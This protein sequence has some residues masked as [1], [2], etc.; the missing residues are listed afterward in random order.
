MKKGERSHTVLIKK[1]TKH[2]ELGDF[3]ASGANDG[4]AFTLIFF[5]G[6]FTVLFLRKFPS[7]KR[8]TADGYV[9]KAS[10]AGQDQ[11]EHRQIAEKILGR[12]LSSREVVH[13]INGRRS[14]NRPQN[15]CV[16]DR[17]EHDRYHGWYDWIYET[18]GNYPRR[19]TQL[20]KLREDFG[21]LLLGDIRKRR[22]G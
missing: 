20:K 13:H 11:Y 7:G 16:M 12:P 4:F 2:K 18:Y 10:A 6:I 22:A 3:K 14:D 8:I 21:G 19:E 5:L 17:V 9:L 1:E 15:L